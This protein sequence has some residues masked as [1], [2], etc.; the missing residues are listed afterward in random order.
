MTTKITLAFLTMMSLAIC[1]QAQV[2]TASFDT[3][4]I[5]SSGV[6]NGSNTPSQNSGFADGNCY[7]STFYDSSFGGYWQGGFALTNIIDTI[8]PSYTNLYG[9]AE[10]KGFNNSANYVVAADYSTM[11]LNNLGAQYKKSLQG[12]HITNTFYA[13]SSML[14]G[15][16]FDPAFGD[17]SL[18][19][20]D[21]FKLSI[22]AYLN[23]N[24][25][26][27]SVEFYLADYRFTDN[28]QDYIIKNWTYVDCSSLGDVDSVS[29]HLSSSR[30]NSLGYTTPLYFAIDELVVK[31]SENSSITEYSKDLISV[32]PNP[33][34][35][36]LHCNID[37][38]EQG[39]IIDE[40]GKTV[41][42]FRDKNIDVSSLVNGIYHVMIKNENQFFQ[43]SFIK[44]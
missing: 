14:N 34:S 1:S 7:F 12:F 19:R 36:Q 26:N 23:G 37:K 20:P 18:N 2:F 44:N 11:K 25:K 30:F 3:I 9:C 21:F 16:S 17:T 28:T 38:L 5:P 31:Y 4:T 39:K 40:M 41:M 22:H 43:S 24:L 8:N 13:Y 33:T 32:F 27:D 10:G 35:A 6:F 29:F 42:T 15:D